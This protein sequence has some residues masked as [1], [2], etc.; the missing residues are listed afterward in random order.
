MKLTNR[1][2]AVFYKNVN[3]W[4][5]PSDFK[6]AFAYWVV[7]QN[8]NDT[9]VVDRPLKAFSEYI[10]KLFINPKVPQAFS[11]DYLKSVITNKIFEGIPEILELNQM[12]PDFID[13]GALARNVIYHI[14]RIAILD[15]DIIQTVV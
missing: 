5:L 6:A 8:P 7:A 9:Y 11:Q 12:K 2:I 13:L 10:E 15:Q 14:L 1:D 4:L 3:A